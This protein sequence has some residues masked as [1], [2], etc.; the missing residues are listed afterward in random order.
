MARAGAISWSLGAAVAAVVLCSP[1]AVPAQVPVDLELVLAIDS[2]DSVNRWE[3][4]LQ[5]EGLASAFRDPD[6][7]AAIQ[8]G[9]FKSI[10]VTLIEWSG[11]YEQATRLPWKLIDGPDSAADFADDISDLRR[12]FDQG[13]TSI[14]GAL[15]FASGLFDDNGFTSFRRVIDISSDGRQNQGRPLS[16]SREE[17]LARD[18]TIN[19]LTILSEM[20]DLD[21]YFRDRVIGGFAAFVEVAQDYPDFPEAIRRKLLREIQYAPI[22]SLPGTADQLAEIDE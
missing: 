19:A 20:E 9:P 4:K 1:Q 14:S 18:I 21:L 17:A 6:V 10:A 2:S 8:S 22:G 12:A 11:R 3:Y 7:L 16:E 15:D 13:V 5:R